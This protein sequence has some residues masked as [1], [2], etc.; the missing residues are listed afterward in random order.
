MDGI[1]DYWVSSIQARLSRFCLDKALSSIESYCVGFMLC[2][3]WSKQNQLYV[4]SD[5][6]ET[7]PVILSKVPD[8]ILAAL[9]DS[10]IL[11]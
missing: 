1:G 8:Q 6:F 9:L 5:K 3:V 2:S 4:I 10:S 7:L 11:V